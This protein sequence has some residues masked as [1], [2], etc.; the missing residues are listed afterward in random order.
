LRY[1]GRQTEG[2]NLHI[3]NIPE[4]TCSSHSAEEWFTRNRGHHASCVYTKTKSQVQASSVS[5]ILQTQVPCPAH[6]EVTPLSSLSQ[7]DL[8]LFCF[9]FSYC[10]TLMNLLDQLEDKFCQ[11]DGILPSSKTVLW[12]FHEG[13][14][15]F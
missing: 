8:S 6:L 10:S 13:G 12:G 7:W 3:R 4:S 2:N 11:A 5:P 15:Q 14:E 1:S 9:L